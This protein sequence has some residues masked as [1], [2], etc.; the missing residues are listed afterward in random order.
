[1]NKIIHTFILFCS[2]FIV[3]PLQSNERTIDEIKDIVC[4]FFSTDSIILSRGISGTTYRN[5]I[6]ISEFKRNNVTYLY[7]VNMP[8]SGWAIVSNEQRYPTT[9]IGYSTTS[10]FETNRDDLPGG[11]LFLLETHMDM[12]DSLRESPSTFY[13]KSNFNSHLSKELHRDIQPL[14]N[15]DGQENSWNQD[16]NNDVSQQ[17]DCNKVYNK[18]CPKLC[19]VSCQRTLAGCTAVAIA[20]VLWYW[21][22]PDYALIYDSIN[23]VG[24]HI[25]NLHRHYYDWDNMP[26]TIN[27][28]TPMYQ[29]NMVAGLLRDC[30]YAA[31]MVYTCIGSSADVLQLEDAL[32]VL[33][34]HWQYNFNYDWT[35]VSSLLINELQ[36]RRP[37]ICQ[38]A[39]G[40]GTHTF[41][42]DGY[43]SGMFHINFGWGGNGNGMWNTDFNGYNVARSFFT[44]LYPNCSTRVAS[45]NNIEESVIESGKNITLYSANNVSLDTLYVKNGGHLNVSAGGTITLKKGFRTQFGCSV[46]LTPNYNCSSNGG[47][48]PVSMPVRNTQNE[49]QTLHTN[50]LSVYPNP[51]T[52]EISILSDIPMKQ[53]SIF[54]IHGQ[55]ILQTTQMRINISHLSQGIYLLYAITESG[56]VLQTKIIHQ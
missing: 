22:W 47:N 56:N 44:E 31:H 45:I 54:N 12:I 3:L 40:I 53:I 8:D 17:Y 7:I 19:N 42:I 13:D 33:N 5:S 30:G 38:A 43:S 23:A 25:G 35:N 16:G 51:A 10:H 52:N 2:L 46:K 26:A 32:D 55:M 49:T 28:S 27:N 15:I 11:V 41:V 14:L 48:A 50:H 36:I 20:Q 37:V 1:M 4:S 18:F 6:Q 29:V 24:S 39:K 9:I 21:K 34:M